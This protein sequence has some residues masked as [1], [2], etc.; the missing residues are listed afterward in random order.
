MKR[1][2]FFIVVFGMLGASTP[3]P[4]MAH[5]NEG[6]CPFAE[7]GAFAS[8]FEG[9]FFH[10]AH[11]LLDNEAELGLTDDQVQ[12]IRGLKIEARKTLITQEAQ[13][14]VLKLDLRSLLDQDTVDTAAAGLLIDQKHEI[15]KA[16]AKDL[17][18]DFA[19]LK[20]V[21]TAEQRQK[22]KALWK[23]KRKSKDEAS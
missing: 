15:E 6:G 20:S 14:E 7:E 22:M 5:H 19:K 2:L 3:S 8:G 17:V 9:M 16:M 12:A 10:K 11:S 13:I 4:A 1:I 23:E 18:A 21:L